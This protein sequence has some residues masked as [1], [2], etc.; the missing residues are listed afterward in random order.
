MTFLTY[1]VFYVIPANPGRLV[2]GSQRNPSP[3]QLERANRLLGTDDPIYVQY[4]RFLWRILHGDFGLSFAEPQRR[5]AVGEALYQASLITGSLVVFG[6]L[7]V[8]LIGLTL[9]SHAAL[10]PSSRPGRALGLLVL[11][12]IA[13]P[14]I[15]SGYLL[16]YLFGAQ[17]AIL[18]D[19]GYCAFFDARGGC[20][21]LAWASHLV[22]PW[23]CF[24][25]AFTALYARIFRASVLEVVNEHYVRTAWA[26]GAST[27][28]VL[29][30]HVFRNALLPIVTIL[31]MDLGTALGVAIYIEWVFGLPGLGFQA[32]G[33]L[34]GNVGFDLP[35]IVGIVLVTSI[36][37]LLLNLAADLLYM[38]LDP[39]IDLAGRDR[40]ARADL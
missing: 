28:R 31:A 32:L 27:W 26:K 21:P 14:P 10:R 33:A 3:E 11:L 24:A 15:V 23:I 5:V 25:L 40:L 18:P 20:G 7:F 4:G 22:L 19:R 35:F 29:R 36:A 13:V 12:G 1:V 16:R 9:G 2:L 8:V 30:A 6:L 37:I 38:G 39:R 34:N 17:W